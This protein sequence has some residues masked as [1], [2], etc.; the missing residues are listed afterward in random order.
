VRFASIIVPLALAAL[1]ALRGAPP[2]QTDSPLPRAVGGHAAAL[3]GPTLWIAGGSFWSEERKRLD[4]TVRRRDSTASGT[5]EIVAKIPGGFAHGGTV[6][7]AHSLW[8]VGG[9]DERGP[10]SAVRRIDLRTGR[11]EIVATLPEA[12][13]Y[14]GAAVLDG[15]L[16]VIGGSASETDFSRTSATVWKI[17]LATHTVHPL[18]TAGPASINPL[19]LALNGELHVLPGSTW[20]EETKRLEAPT[21]VEIFSPGTGRW[22]RRALPAVLPRG[23][24][25]T[26][27]DAHRAVLAGGVERRDSASV[28]G[29]GVWLY[30]ARDGALTPQGTLPGPRLAAAMVTADRG[31]V[32]LLGGEDGPRRRVATVWRR[33]GETEGAK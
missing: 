28:I 18:P 32:L 23:L 31:A 6:P 33:A 19:V 22:T 13:V 7:D 20:S 29:S 2:W 17:D 11:V 8:L 14:C 12:R 15:A 21:A 24:S 27:L 30:D 4:D 9:L 1:P 16:W 10:S 25:G 5:W 26:A 3:L